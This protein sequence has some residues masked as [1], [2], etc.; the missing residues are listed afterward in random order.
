M[1]PARNKPAEP[2]S[3]RRILA[4]VD[5]SQ[6]AGVVLR[7]TLRFSR[8]FAAEVAVLHVDPLEEGSTPADIHGRRAHLASELRSLLD[9]LD[10]GEHVTQAMLLEG[11]PGAQVVDYAEREDFDLIVIGG[12]SNAAERLLPGSTA[13]DVLRRAHCPVLC[14]DVRHPL[15]GRV[16]SVIYAAD[17][18]PPSVRSAALSAE[19]AARLSATLTLVHVSGCLSGAEYGLSRSEAL[20][21]AAEADA[22]LDELRRHLAE[23]VRDCGGNARNVLARRVEDKDLAHGVLRAAND[24]RADLIVCGACELLRHEHRRLGWVCEGILRRAT[25][26]VLVARTP[27][28]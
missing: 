20:L 2:P 27:V 5:L 3:L 4:A 11:K 28:A 9:S 25:C 16:R 1:G 13:V 24:A 23:R 22:A 6:T 8:S 19:L 14:V 10:G 15:E 26:S 18:R 17:L 12:D 7:T 21:R